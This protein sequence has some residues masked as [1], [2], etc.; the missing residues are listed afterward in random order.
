MTTKQQ[1]LEE[2]VGPR[3]FTAADA[4]DPQHQPPPA[5]DPA[6]EAA[7]HALKELAPEAEILHLDAGATYLVLVPRDTE[8]Q[9]AQN[10]ARALNIAGVKGAVVR[11]QEPAAI[12]LFKL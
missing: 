6:L 3:S 2:G 11:V 9:Q 5:V 4:V 12:R 1:P 10:M 8:T 7:L